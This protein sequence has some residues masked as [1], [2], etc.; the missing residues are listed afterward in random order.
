M[1]DENRSVFPQRAALLFCTNEL[2]LKNMQNQP[3]RRIDDRYEILSEIGRGAM[4]TVYKVRDLVVDRIVA[5]KQLNEPD[6]DLVQAFEK[7]FVTLS[8]LRH[9]NLARVYDFSH[10][11]SKSLCYFTMD[12]VDGDSIA[13]HQK[14][15]AKKPETLYPVLSEMLSALSYIHSKKI[16]HGDLKPSNVMVEGAGIP[17]GRRIKLLDFGLSKPMESSAARRSE[18]FSGTLEYSAPEIL[19]GEAADARSDFYALGVILY[20]LLS[21]RNPFQDSDPGKT[22]RN[23]IEK[24]PQPVERLNQNVPPVLAE[25]ITALLSK[26]PRDR[27][28]SAEEILARLP[29]ARG[30]QEQFRDDVFVCRERELNVLKRSFIRSADRHVS[31]IA[32]SGA[33]GT[34]KSRLLESFKTFVQVEK[35]LFLGASS[36][37]ERPGASSVLSSL[38]RRLVFRLGVSH[39]LVTDYRADLLL[40]VADLDGNGKEDPESHVADAGQQVLLNLAEFVIRAS[41]EVQIVLAVEDVVFHPTPLLD[42]LSHLTRLSSLGAGESGFVVC[43]SGTWESEEVDAALGTGFEFVRLENLDRNELN[44]FVR[45]ALNAESV[46]GDITGFV[47]EQTNGN[48]FFAS[49]MLRYLID[50]EV[51]T[52]MDTAWAFE[53][54]PGLAVPVKIEEF[55]ER[56]VAALDPA[57]RALLEASAVGLDGVDSAFVKHLLGIAAPDEQLDQLVK[58]RLLFS[59][60]GVYRFRQRGLWNKVLAQ[61]SDAVGL[62]TR[63]AQY[64]EALKAPAEWAENLAYHYAES[65]SPLKALPCL[66]LAGDR[67]NRV[68]EPARADA[69]YSQAVTVLQQNKDAID[70]EAFLDQQFVVLK[71]RAGTLGR[72]GDRARQSEDIETLDQIS[73]EMS[74]DAVAEVC[75]IKAAY[76]FDTSELEKM[77]AAVDA[78]LEIA[79]RLKQVD[80]LAEALFFRGQYHFARGEYREALT[81]Y[82]EAGKSADQDELRIKIMNGVGVCHASL[83]DAASA[84][85]SF[86]HVA[87]LAESAG[88]PETQIKALFNIGLI[89][90]RQ[91]QFEEAFGY[92][93]RGQALALKVNS[94]IHQLLYFTAVE[95][96]QSARRD[97]GSV[98]EFSGKALDLAEKLGDR[99]RERFALSEQAKLFLETGRYEEAHRALERAERLAREIGNETGMSVV[100]HYQA[101]L[102]AATGKPEANR[103]MQAAL[104]IAQKTGNLKL[105]TLYQVYLAQFLIMAGNFHEASV[106]LGDLFG[107]ADPEAVS[108]EALYGLSFYTFALA[109]TGDQDAALA[110]LS[111]LRAALEK[112]DTIEY[113]EE[114]ICFNVY[115]TLKTLVLSGKK[116]S[117]EEGEAFPFL[118]RARNAVFRIGE[119]IRGLEQRQSYFNLPLNRKI[120][121]EYQSVS[122][123]QQQSHAESFDS[124]FEISKVINSIL[125]P[126]LLFEKIM[127]LAIE[128]TQADRGMVLLLGEDDPGALEI[129]VARNMEKETIEDAKD[130]SRS[131]VEDVYR[132]NV[133]VLSSNAGLDE[134][135]KNRMSIMKY[136]IRSIMCVPLRVRGRLIGTVYLDKRLD[137]NSFTEYHLKFLESFSNLAAVSIENARMY[138]RLREEKEQLAVENKMLHLEVKDKFLFDNIVG[139]GKAMET[140]SRGIRAALNNNATVLIS[141]DSGTGKELIA[142]AIAYH[143]QRKDR[144]FVAVDCGA[145]SE[146]LLESELFGHKKGAFTGATSDKKGLFEEADGGT[147]FLDEIT[148]TSMNLQSRLLRAI[149]EGEIRRVGE[150]S[151]RH[152]D[153]RI[154]AATNRVL[155]EEVK[156][157]RFREDLFY[158]LNVLPIRVPPLRERREDVPFLVKFFLERFGETLGKSVTSVSEPLLNAL[159]RYDWPGNV[160]ELE[161]ILQRMVIFSEGPVLRDEDLP[162]EIR[163]KMAIGQSRVF[164][165]GSPQQGRL[166]TLDDLENARYQVELE[167][168]REILRKA[169]GNKTRAAEL[170]GINRTT[171]NDRLRKVGLL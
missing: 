82:L 20:E 162:A 56:T 148:N 92:Y 100:L 126:D 125:E 76:Y 158:R 155:E 157:G 96:I 71:K 15:F 25:I 141:G 106:Q 94:K 4:G 163:E 168:Y 31:R 84:L 128:T 27:Y 105:Q 90:R 124:L 21:G 102:Q 72:L 79:G 43:I 54:R 121:D 63:A 30:S 6:V 133:S 114:E 156:A 85:D 1:N 60:D 29:V 13:V 87:G 145:L 169:G 64:F 61:L 41:R 70:D 123:A 144:K 65:G 95:N 73:G 153:V 93:D 68:F 23:Q 118:E 10:V 78:C 136:N 19:S 66:I 12:Y 3:L 5:L 46:E 50:E 147:I 135:F 26:L 81:N 108:D 160:R 127:D 171:L 16:L 88:F 45:A 131:I 69:L 51:L 37:D 55:N 119:S 170:L 35:G 152:V 48:L 58:R 132:Q 57:T 7:E 159:V 97:Y 98:L 40:Y 107:S 47:F 28:G 39:E 115:R 161:N 149:Q 2:I 59:E 140:V 134:R 154:I 138:Q 91:G 110:V 167:F 109:Q 103:T 129:R 117:L 112:R 86:E 17:A 34:G 89:Y 142:R 49:E 164:S 53:K 75:L 165:P 80:R 74:A 52:R 116:V 150:T 62:H 113:P 99:A 143:G 32:I 24:I 36:S 44:T 9:E 22:I 151:F 137:Q 33:R 18:G 166:E 11:Q 120:V 146:T 111:T 67:A 130:I 122:A 77:P 83:D 139:H 101:R 104:D 14:A 8:S 42:F 38:L